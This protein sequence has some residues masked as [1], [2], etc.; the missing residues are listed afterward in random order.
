M[1]ANVDFF[2][3][4]S[5]IPGESLKEGHKD[6]IEIESWAWG[7]SNSGSHAQGAGGGAGKVAMQDFS[8]TMPMNKASPKLFLACATGKHIP[9]AL[10]TCRQAGGKQVEYLKVKFSDLLVSAYQTG[11]GDGT[12]KPIENVTF[13]FSKIEF[14]YAPQKPD[15]SP[16]TFVTHWYNVKETTAA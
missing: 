6:E 1:A 16:G 12:V 14:S 5:G 10:L 2:L 9:E 11:A 8:F 15:G 7:E 13:N 3:K 4:I